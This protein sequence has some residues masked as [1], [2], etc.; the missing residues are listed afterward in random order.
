VLLLAGG[1]AIALDLLRSKEVHRFLLNE[2]MLAG[3]AVIAAAYA[4]AWMMWR[5][6]ESLVEEERQVPAGLVATANAFTLFFVSVDLW[7]YVGR[8]ASVSGVVSAQQL[9]LSLFWTVYA[10]AL[11]S[12]GI[13]L[14]ARPVRLFGVGLLYLSVLKVFLFD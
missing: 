10:L 6:K 12:V 11:I 8:Q 5:W 2:R 1:R 4:A 7:E 14:R 9:A 3:L 13:W